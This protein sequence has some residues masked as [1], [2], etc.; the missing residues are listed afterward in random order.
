MYEQPV[1]SLNNKYKPCSVMKKTLNILKV[2]TNHSY[3][4]GNGPSGLLWVLFYLVCKLSKFS[5][6]VNLVKE[7]NSNIKV[8][9]TDA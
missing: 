4:F 3:L 9:R 2:N 5:A 8:L 1:L 7:E 6:G